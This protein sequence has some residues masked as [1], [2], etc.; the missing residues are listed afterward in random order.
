MYPSIGGV[1][2]AMNLFAGKGVKSGTKA[3]CFNLSGNASM[4]SFLHFNRL[5]SAACLARF[6]LIRTRLYSLASRFPSSTVSSY[7]GIF[8]SSTNPRAI[9]PSPGVPISIGSSGTPMACRPPFFII[10]FSRRRSLLSRPNL[11]RSASRACSLGLRYRTGVGALMHSSYNRC[12]SESWREMGGSSPDLP[13]PPLPFLV[14]ILDRF[15]GC[16]SLDLPLAVPLTAQRCT[17]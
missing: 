9:N 15:L 6:F 3:A 2:V 12:F 13:P 17:N 14:E 5:V 16:P 11:S 4:A 7:L 8:S 1:N 10:C